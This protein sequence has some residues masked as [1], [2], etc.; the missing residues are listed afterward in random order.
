MRFRILPIPKA[1]PDTAATY[2]DT[3]VN[4]K[5]LTELVG[6]SGGKGLPTEEEE[7]LP[8]SHS[9]PDLHTNSMGLHSNTQIDKRKKL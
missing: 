9:C 1:I 7:N 6:G 3:S 5:K 2:F 4:E 8:I